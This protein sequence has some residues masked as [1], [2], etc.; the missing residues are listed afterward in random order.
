MV[1]LS[2]S[3]ALLGDTL[4]NLAEALTAGPLLVAF[5]LSARPAA[6]PMATGSRR[7]PCWPGRARVHRSIER[8]RGLRRHRPA[9]TSAK[10]QL[11]ARRGT[12]R[13]D[14]I[15]WQR[16][17]GA[18]SDRGRSSDRT[19]GLVADGLH[20][21]TDGFTSLAVLVGAPST[22]VPPTRTPHINTS[23]PTRGTRRVAKVRGLLDLEH[24]RPGQ[25]SPRASSCLAD[26]KTLGVATGSNGSQRTT[27]GVKVDLPYPSATGNRGLPSRRFGRLEFVSAQVSDPTTLLSGFPGCRDARC[28]RREPGSNEAPPC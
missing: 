22:R 28:I 7:G 26:R 2:G 16:G 5:R 11:P 1:A 8:R 24:P 17:R 25:T 21:R 20:T 9:A 27:D 10:D 14:R 23:C 12:R 6:T 18:L 3:V 15:P 19:A 4:H 13:P